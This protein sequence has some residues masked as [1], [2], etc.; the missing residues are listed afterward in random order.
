MSFG[1]SAP[2]VELEGDFTTW[3]IQAIYETGVTT[4]GA[5]P[6]G[7]TNDGTIFFNDYSK[8]ETYIIDHD[9]TLLHTLTGQKPGYSWWGQSSSLFN[10]YSLILDGATG[11]VVIVITVEGTLWSRSIDEDKNG[12]TLD[13]GTIRGLYISQSGEWILVNARST[14]GNLLFIYKGS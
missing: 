6:I 12:Y 9:G 2:P 14:V 1:A 8:Q 11:H 5:D 13:A 3:T 10:R 4:E 7:I